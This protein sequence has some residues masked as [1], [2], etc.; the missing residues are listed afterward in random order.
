VK[1]NPLN[2]SWR[3]ADPFAGSI[4]ILWVTYQFA[5]MLLH[6]FGGHASA[7]Y[8]AS[9]RQALPRHVVVDTLEII[10]LVALIKGKPIAFW[11]FFVFDIFLLACTAAYHVKGI[12]TV[13]ADRRGTSVAYQLVFMSYCGIRILQIRLE[14]ERALGRFV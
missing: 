13:W 6:L 14:R 9:T 1:Q 8:I 7:L 11:S 5:I 3:R 10:V 2:Q 12:D 4:T